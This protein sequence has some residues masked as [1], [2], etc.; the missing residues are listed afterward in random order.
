MIVRSF[1]TASAAIVLLTTLAAAAKD[2]VP[3]IDLEKRCRT[4]AKSTQTLMGGTSTEA[5]EKAYQSCMSSETEARKAILA[6]WK[7]IPP[8]YKSFCVRPNVYSP[9][10]IEWIACLE[11][12][13]DLKRLRSQPS[14]AKGAR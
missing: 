3:S 2:I 6:A 11:M 10:Y 12:N 4:S 9:S 14:D 5:A 13:I 8:S 7:D 1:V